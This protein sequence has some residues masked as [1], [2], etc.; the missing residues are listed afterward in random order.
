MLSNRE[1]RGKGTGGRAHSQPC[2]LIKTCLL[3]RNVY[4][5][6]SSLRLLPLR[7]SNTAPATVAGGGAGGADLGLTL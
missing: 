6:F 5:A 2:A 3:R 1:E 7:G 4:A